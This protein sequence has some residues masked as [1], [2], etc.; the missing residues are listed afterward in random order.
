MRDR[1]LGYATANIA[2]F[3]QPHDGNVGQP[4]SQP[5]GKIGVV[6]RLQRKSAERI[7]GHRVESC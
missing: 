2:A 1:T 5:L 4:P 6:F 7:A 3:Q